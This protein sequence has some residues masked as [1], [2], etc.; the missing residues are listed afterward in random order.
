LVCPPLQRVMCRLIDAATPGRKPVQVSDDELLARGNGLAEFIVDERRRT[1]D[2]APARSS[3]GPESTS[4]GCDRR[5]RLRHALVGPRRGVGIRQEQ[6]P[7][8]HL[9]CITAGLD[10]Q[11]AA[12]AQ[13]PPCCDVG[14]RSI[15]SP[16]RRGSTSRRSWHALYNL[17]GMRHGF[18]GGP[19]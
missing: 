8:P 4:R 6:A 2:S 14:N 9:G 16:E 15:A 17:I 7:R 10:D 13:T 12:S 3:R 18:R 19:G 11:T 1:P 5:L